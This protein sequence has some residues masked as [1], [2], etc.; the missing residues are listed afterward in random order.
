M[1]IRAATS[2]DWPRTWPF[3]SAMVAAGETYAYP[4]DLMLDTGRALWMYRRL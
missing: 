1:I 3:F 2:Q 4:E